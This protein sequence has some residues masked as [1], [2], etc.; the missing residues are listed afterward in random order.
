MNFNVPAPTNP[1]DSFQRQSS[2]LFLLLRRNP[3]LVGNLVSE[4]RDLGSGKMVPTTIY[5]Y[6]PTNEDERK[7][8]DRE[9]HLF[10]K[11]VATADVTV[12]IWFF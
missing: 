12:K 11:L 10:T 2:E 3:F 1:T 7:V 4:M 8:R 9:K 6:Q 5:E